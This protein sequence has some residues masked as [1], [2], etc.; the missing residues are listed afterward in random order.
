M[1]CTRPRKKHTELQSSDLC[2]VRLGMSVGTSV[3]YSTH[4]HL[5]PPGLQNLKPAKTGLKAK[6]NGK[7]STM[8]ICGFKSLETGVPGWSSGSTRRAFSVDRDLAPWATTDTPSW[9]CA[10]VSEAPLPPPPGRGGG[11]RARWVEGAGLRGRLP[12]ITR[13][14]FHLL[15]GPS[16]R[17]PS[18]HLVFFAC[19]NE[20]NASSYTAQGFP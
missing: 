19:E 18:L 15:A 13:Q 11:G 6:K 4:E 10:F 9:A 16:A 17:M 3:I 8:S 1:P 12:K 14:T 5:S 7:N 20:G 2:R